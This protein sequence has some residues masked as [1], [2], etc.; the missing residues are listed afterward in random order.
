MMATLPERPEAAP[1]PSARLSETAARM[2]EAELYRYKE[3]KREIQDRRNELVNGPEDPRPVEDAGIRT[4][5]A[6]SDP[7]SFRASL[8]YDDRRLREMRRIVRA[9][10]D[11]HAAVR[12]EVARFMELWFWSNVGTHAC[13]TTLEISRETAFRWRKAILAEVAARLGWQ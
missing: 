9:I 1:E 3:L 11:T 2:V 5:T 7:T 12:P 6:W 8:L 13:T 10:E 4:A